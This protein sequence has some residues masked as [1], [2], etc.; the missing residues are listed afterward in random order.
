[1]KLPSSRDMTEQIVLSRRFEQRFNDQ[2][3]RIV[4]GFQQG[5]QTF[6]ALQASLSSL[7]DRVTEEHER[8][9]RHVTDT[10][11]AQ[12]QAK[13]DDLLQRLIK[14]LLWEGWD[15]RQAEVAVAHHG[16]ET[17][18]L[19]EPEGNAWPSFRAWL[20][21]LDQHLVYWISGKPGAGKSTLTK[22]LS[23]QGEPSLRNLLARRAQGINRTVIIAS[24]F[25]HLRG[26]SLQNSIGGMLQSLLGQMLRQLPTWAHSLC[27][28]YITQNWP[29]AILTKLVTRILS[30]LDTSY[31][32]CIIVDGLDECTSDRDDLSQLLIGFTTCGRCETRVL[33]ASRHWPV[34]Q[35]AFAYSG[36]ASTLHL[37]NY[38]AS[39]ILKYVQEKLSGTDQFRSLERESHLE[40]EELVSILT[41]RAR[42][43]W[44]WVRI[45][46]KQIR[47]LLTLRRT[48]IH[49]LLEEASRLPKELNEMYDHVVD[50]VDPDLHWDCA[51]LLI[52]YQTITETPDPVDFC[53][54]QGH[55][56]SYALCLNI[57]DDEYA[58][59]DQAQR[60]QNLKYDFGMHSDNSTGGLLEE[61]C[62]DCARISYAYSDDGQQVCEC[63]GGPVLQLKSAHLTVDEWLKKDGTQAILRAC[64]PV[65]LLDHIPK[66]VA[67]TLLAQLPYTCFERDLFKV[68]VQILEKLSFA[69]LVLVDESAVCSEQFALI[70]D[71]LSTVL[72]M[73]QAASLSVERETWLRTLQGLR[74]PF[75]ASALDLSTHETADDTSNLHLSAGILFSS[76][77]GILICSKPQH[78]LG[79]L[80]LHASPTDLKLALITA[81][82]EWG[83]HNKTNICEQSTKAICELLDQGV[84]PNW[85]VCGNGCS[86]WACFL[87]GANCKRDSLNNL[88]NLPSSSDRSCVE[89]AFDNNSLQAKQ[90]IG[91]A[92]QF[93]AKGAEK[94]QDLKLAVP[95]PSPTSG[96]VPLACQFLRPSLLQVLTRY[97]LYDGPVARDDEWRHYLQ[98]NGWE[99][100]T[101]TPDKGISPGIASW[102]INGRTSRP[103]LDEFDVDQTNEE[104]YDSF[105]SP[106]S[107]AKRLAEYLPGRNQRCRAIVQRIVK[108]EQVG[109]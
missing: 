27:E 50:R 32:V 57:H 98:R 74:H 78:D 79:G 16:T 17:W 80:Y 81:V 34:F 106:T 66:L 60:G 23:E 93:L 107:W 48:N 8:T 69:S 19:D 14:S 20:T 53:S 58:L 51:V 18:I 95:K 52:L 90:F 105:K 71:N 13:N 56:I 55:R 44:I 84:D 30:G 47:R 64:A 4:E 33:V 67:R 31:V 46:V 6:D 104:W 100:T 73:I 61:S 10:F 22:Y 24:H 62:W 25:F 5:A 86:A 15:H 28:S 82:V 85:S 21:G 77:L 35:D 43:V 88:R 96:S 65:G 41:E 70:L 89:L 36:K 91:I 75:L 26:S 42:G 9:R 103:L 87:V 63:D 2:E 72:D 102:Y 39:D 59:D 40:T 54:Y 49:F 101:T 11:T 109:R 3:R 1:M 37:H 92:T 83:E 97:G 29:E 12:Q 7:H 68:H 108:E 94:I 76:L 99:H 38:T 45:A